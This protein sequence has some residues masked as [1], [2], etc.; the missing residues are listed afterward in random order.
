MKE[1]NIPIVD[2]PYGD[3]MIGDASGKLMNEYG[4]F[5]CKIKCG[6]YALLVRGTA[7]A[8][9]NVTDYYF[10]ARAGKFL[11]HPRDLRGCLGLLDCFRQ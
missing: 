8:T 6:V 9:I 2:C 7:H 4:R 5:P 1:N 10:A 11:P 3:Y